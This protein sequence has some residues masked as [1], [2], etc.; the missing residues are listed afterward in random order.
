MQQITEDPSIEVSMESPAFGDTD[1][2][3]PNT[4]KKVDLNPI[5]KF[6]KRR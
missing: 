2:K 4:L 6:E 3:T 1:Q 5:E